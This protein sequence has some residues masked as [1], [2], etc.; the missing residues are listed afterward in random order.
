MQPDSP[1]RSEPKKGRFIKKKNEQILIEE[2]VKRD[3]EH[4]QQ[5]NNK[6]SSMNSLP[7]REERF[8]AASYHTEQQRLPGTAQQNIDP[9][10]QSRPRASGNSRGA[11]ALAPSNAFAREDSN[12]K[13]SAAS[14]DRG[15]V[16]RSG[17][18]LLERNGVALPTTPSIASQ[19]RRCSLRRRPPPLC[20]ARR[21]VG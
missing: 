1:L 4:L 12:S 21:S 7:T 19:A 14:R 16:G 8:S 18:G 17:A 2:N 11:S 10:Y 3:Q 5:T 20:R 9:F 6:Q 15:R 13:R